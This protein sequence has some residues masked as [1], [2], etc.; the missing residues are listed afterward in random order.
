MTKQNMLFLR[1]HLAKAGRILEAYDTSIPNPL[2]KRFKFRVEHYMGRED[3]VVECVDG[4][5][6]LDNEFFD[7]IFRT[8]HHLMFADPINWHVRYVPKDHTKFFF[9][10]KSECRE[11]LRT[12]MYDLANKELDAWYKK[13]EP[14]TGSRFEFER[15]LLL[16]MRD[17]F[18]TKGEY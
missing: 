17:K 1:S 14:V 8:F 6:K 10:F 15:A 11:Y 4:I 3:E 9:E 16:W 12:V 2:E 13:N 18:G 5:I 7:S